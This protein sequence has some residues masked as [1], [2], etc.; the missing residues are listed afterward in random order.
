MNDSNE[1]TPRLAGAPISWG[2]CEVP[3]WGI[4]LPS[5]RVLADMRDLG[6]GAT[7]LGPDGFLPSDPARLHAL[8]ESF[9]LELCGG[10][11]TAALAH[12]DL[13]AEIHQVQSHVDTLAG[14][15]AHTMVLALVSG[16]EGYDQ[17]PSLEARE[18]ERVL[19]G[20]ERIRTL[21]E[22]AGMECALH[23][24]VGTLVERAHDVE[25]VQDNADIGWCLD[26]GHLMVGGVDP[27][28]FTRANAQRIT[29]VHLKDVDAAVAAQVARGQLGYADA[30]AAGLYVPLGAGD[31]DM[32]SIITTLEHAHYRGWYVLE[33]DMRLTADDASPVDAAR[34]S[35]DATRNLFAGLVQ[36]AS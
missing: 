13:E 18:W 28:E 4:Q 14:A 2:V 26:T 36:G 20:V 19:G 31:I 35:I 25:I 30:V 24:H 15:G 27:V 11:V 6:L 9:G 34:A 1:H 7:E 8:L 16:H 12:G 29:H 5:E 22:Q 3:N 33:Q 17:A 23:P 32:E 21:V 10:F